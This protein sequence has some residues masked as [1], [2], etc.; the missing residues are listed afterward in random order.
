[1]NNA[2][3]L[4]SLRE[5]RAKIVEFNA[6]GAEIDR[7]MATLIA[8]VEAD[9]DPAAE[10]D[11]ERLATVLAAHRKLMFRH[12]ERS[13]PTESVCFIDQQFSPLGPRNHVAAVKR[14]VAERHARELVAGRPPGVELDAAIIGRRHLLSLAALTEEYFRDGPGRGPRPKG[15]RL[16]RTNS[17]GGAA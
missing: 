15:S 2:D 12:A 8:E 9:G 11:R 1:M 6:L 13:L 14:R 17:K 16:V 5:L 7:R 3:I 4:V 10:A